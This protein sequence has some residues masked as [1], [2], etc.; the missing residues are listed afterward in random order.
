MADLVTETVSVLNEH[1]GAGIRRGVAVSG[2]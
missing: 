2:I 1:E